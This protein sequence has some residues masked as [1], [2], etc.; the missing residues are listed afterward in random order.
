MKKLKSNYT[1]GLAA[2]SLFVA[3]LFSNN[4]LT[5]LFISVGAMRLGT[6]IE[7]K[8]INR[9]VRIIFGLIGVVGII[10]LTISWLKHGI[11]LDYSFK[12]IF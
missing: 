1:I 11:T 4:I 7:D 8:I 12:N 9:K 5:I 3:I 2:F 10:L 6:L